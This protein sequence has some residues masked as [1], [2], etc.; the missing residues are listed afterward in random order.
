[1]TTGSLT[2]TF[3][4]PQQVSHLMLQEYIP[5]GQRVKNFQVEYQNGSVWVPL[6]LDEETTTIGY[7]RILRF[8]EI[9][10]SAIRINFTDARGPLCI[11]EVAAF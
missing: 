5:L 11:S 4:Q 3:N 9:T 1:M 7:K 2:F 8:P 6:P 10:S